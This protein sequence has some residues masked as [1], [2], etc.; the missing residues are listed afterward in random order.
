MDRFEFWQGDK[1]LGK[2][3]SVN[4]FYQFWKTADQIYVFRNEKGLYNDLNKGL[5]EVEQYLIKKEKAI[6]KCCHCMHC[7]NRDN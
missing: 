7:S 3:D 5:S 4:G 1:Y 6:E 2:A